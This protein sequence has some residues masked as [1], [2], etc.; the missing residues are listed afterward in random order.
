MK[1]KFIIAGILFILF[2][3]WLMAGNGQ[4]QIQTR[5]VLLSGIPGGIKV[6]FPG[7]NIGKE[8]TIVKGDYIFTGILE[9]SEIVL[10]K[11]IAN[12]RHDNKLSIQIDNRSTTVDM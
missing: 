9:T 8:I 10:T 1:K 11:L 3:S 4:S 6:I 12:D 5:G 7:K 2:Q